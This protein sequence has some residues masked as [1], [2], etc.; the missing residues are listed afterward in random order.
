MGL[1]GYEKQ[2]LCYICTSARTL[3]STWNKN[4][5]PTFLSIWEI[6]L[7]DDAAAAAVLCIFFQ[8]EVWRGVTPLTKTSAF[9][10]EF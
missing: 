7:S 2:S 4:T 6:F 9:R 8:N 1:M 10:P 3:R 5:A